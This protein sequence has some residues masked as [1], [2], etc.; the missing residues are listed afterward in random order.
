M[1]SIEVRNEAMLYYKLNK[2]TKSKLH[3]LF[4]FNNLIDA[5]GF[6]SYYENY[7]ILYG[8]G[9]IKMKLP[10]GV[11]SSSPYILMKKYWYRKFIVS[12]KNWPSGTVIYKSFIPLRIEE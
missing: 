6:A 5:K 4:L 11:Y 10:F 12:E 9:K 8:I 1:T 3:G 2:L 7:K